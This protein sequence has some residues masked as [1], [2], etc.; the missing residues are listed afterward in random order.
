MKRTVKVKWGEVRVGLLLVFAVTAVLW[1]TFSGGG[2]SLLESKVNYMA[3]FDNVQGLVT[4]SPVWIAGV[5]VGNIYSI[6]FVNYDSTDQIQVRFRILK[7]VQNMITTDAKAMI[8]TIGLIGDKYIEIIPGTLT[9]PI[10]QEESAINSTRPADISQAFA[11]GEQAM[12]S[13]RE[14]ADNL[15]EV[16]RRIKR[17]EGSIGKVFLYDTLHNEIS[18]LVAALTILIRDMQKTQGKVIASIENI[19]T[20]LD[21]I[22]DKVNSNQGT[23][24]KIISDPSVFDNLHSSTGRIDSILAR[25]ARGDGTA[26]AMITD[27]ELYQETKNLIV[28]IENLVSD[29]EQ[30]PRKYFKFSV[31]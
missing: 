21:G 30:N 15:N 29:I 6:E 12:E 8:G 19:S 1:A 18:D 17:G 9:N 24:G 31:F 3:Y 10:L 22:I 7:S 25:I 28:R 5:E 14:L 16:T 2:T 11:A 23:L 4:G 20:N 13:T 27:D 26:G